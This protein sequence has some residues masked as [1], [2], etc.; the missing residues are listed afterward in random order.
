MPLKIFPR[1]LFHSFQHDSVISPQ[2]I[3]TIKVDPLK[4]RLERNVSVQICSRNTACKVLMRACKHVCIALHQHQK[5]LSVPL[6][7]AAHSQ[8]KFNSTEIAHRVIGKFNVCPFAV[9]YV[10]AADPLVIDLWE[11]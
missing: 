11:C 9:Q 4:A 7:V 6:L 3:Y 10:I 2:Y 5:V 1:S 8:A